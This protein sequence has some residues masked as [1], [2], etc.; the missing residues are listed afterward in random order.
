MQS[1]LE[2]ALSHHADSG[3]A[4]LYPQLDL[5]GLYV[6]RG[7]IGTVLIMTVNPLSGPGGFYPGGQYAFHIDRTGSTIP[8]L[9]FRAT[10]SD[11]LHDR[12]L[13]QLRQLGGHRAGDR[14]AAGEVIAS[15]M[16]GTLIQSRTG[17]RLW[18][19]AA[20]DPDWMHDGVLSAAQECIA[21][22]SPFDPHLGTSGHAMNILAYSNIQALVLEL[23]PSMLGT[24]EIRVWATTAMPG[25]RDTWT[26]VNR[27]A[28]PLLNT[29]FDIDNELTGLYHNATSP[30]GDRELYGDVI[31]SGAARAARALGSVTDPAAHGDRVAAAL[32][33]DVLTYQPG[34][35]AHFG[36]GGR[37][38]RGLRDPAAE[39]VLSLI[40]GTDIPL[41]ID[42]S[43][44]TG[45]LRA[46]FPYLSAPIDTAEPPDP[47]R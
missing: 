26:Q 3:L 28:I 18:A 41:G 34:T 35:S 12:Q 47:F 33:P 24:G 45:Y 14:N 44:A 20:A 42:A 5:C 4:L 19:G 2:R 1:R 11:E 17:A 13:I 37:N 16:S 31:R 25:D 29:L 32:L 9:T 22:G 21:K 30:A 39:A 10:F 36:P 27:C 40:M 43:S 23:P 7:S 8:D 6:F 46:V 38:G 15:G